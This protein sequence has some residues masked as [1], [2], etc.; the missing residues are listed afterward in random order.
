MPA[1]RNNMRTCDNCRRVL[2]TLLVQDARQEFCSEWCTNEWS[3]KRIDGMG[4]EA[5][6]EVLDRVKLYL[7]AVKVNQGVGAA[8]SALLLAAQ[9]CWPHQ[10]STS[11]PQLVES[12]KTEQPLPQPTLFQKQ[13]AATATT[14]AAVEPPLQSASEQEVSAHEPVKDGP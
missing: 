10:Q 4:T 5:L 12:D 13:G 9:V 2:S 3:A 11:K 8:L 6:H 1:S 7:K 14:A